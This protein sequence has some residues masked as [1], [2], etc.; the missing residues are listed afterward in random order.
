MLRQQHPESAET[1]ARWLRAWWLRDQTAAQN[2]LSPDC[3]A[4]R[5]HAAAR[6]H[7][8]AAMRRDGRAAAVLMHGLCVA[9]LARQPRAA[10]R[11]L[12]ARWLRGE[13]AAREDGRTAVARQDNRVARWPIARQ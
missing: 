10:G 12:R 4:A 11:W 13:T 5:F 1:A 7:G 9:R 8:G 3:T 6:Q 2:G